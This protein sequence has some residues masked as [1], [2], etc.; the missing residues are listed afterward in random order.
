MDSIFTSKKS[1]E[2]EFSSTHS[3]LSELKQLKAWKSESLRIKDKY[4][5][6]KTESLMKDSNTKTS[7]F[8][9]TKSF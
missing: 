2:L 3:N 8:L 7:F 1:E 6:P 4:F 9:E 5:Y